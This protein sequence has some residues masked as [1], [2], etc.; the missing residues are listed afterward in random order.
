MTQCVSYIALALDWSTLTYVSSFSL[1]VNLQMRRYKMSQLPETADGIAQWCQNLFVA[2][3]WQIKQILII[4]LFFIWSLIS[5]VKAG[6]STWKLLHKWCVQR[7]GRSPNWPA[8]QTTDR[9]NLSDYLKLLLELTISLFVEPSGNR[10][11]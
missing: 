8:N 10:W 2:K 11:C 4:K 3:V 6:C 5:F 9:K 1:K 7:L